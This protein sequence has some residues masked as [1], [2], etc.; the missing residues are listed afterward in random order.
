MNDEDFIVFSYPNSLNSYTVIQFTESYSSLNSSTISILLNDLLSIAEST[1]RTEVDNTNRIKF[2]NESPFIIYNC[3]Y[4]LRDILGIYD[5]Q[6]PINSELSNEKYIIQSL[7]VGNYLSTPILYL[8][9][10]IGEK[11]FYNNGNGTSNR[12]ILM[13]INNSYS[14]NFPVICNNAEF[15]T[16][17]LSNDF[18]DITFE[19][20][21]ARFKPIKLLSP[22]FLC[23]TI[24]GN[25][26]AETLNTAPT[27]P[28]L[29]SKL[30]GNHDSFE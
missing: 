30:N 23:G 2:S 4:R 12:K 24:Q 8:L 19:L 14:A 11:C 13:R 1:I 25:P 7:S 10:S 18:S 29:L 28:F 9:A 27:I 20:V 17:A 15:S 5:Q 22:M 3:S 26:Q 6:L 16:Y 21:D